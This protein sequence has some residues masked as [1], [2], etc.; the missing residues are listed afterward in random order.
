MNNMRKIM[1]ILNEDIQMQTTMNEGIGGAVNYRTSKSSPDKDYV[2]QITRNGEKLEDDKYQSLEDAKRVITNMKKGA[3]PSSKE[4]YK[5][6]KMKRPKLAGP[7]GKLPEAAPGD[8][9]EAGGKRVSIKTPW[10]FSGERNEEGEF[11]ENLEAQY[12]V[13]I[14]ISWLRGSA[15][16][17]GVPNDLVKYLKAMH[18][19]MS[20]SDMVD[21]YPE[22][23]FE[24]VSEDGILDEGAYEK[25]D[26]KHPKFK[27]NH[28]KWKEKNPS[29]TLAQFIAHMN[30][31]S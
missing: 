13:N 10:L 21:K 12:N 5:I 26:P 20:F 6:L 3:N 4:T 31:A 15:H 30:N 17:S 28:D 18:D 24:G 14:K 1:N 16:V 23:W 29:G 2:Y 19:N 22:M 25:S 8:V 11:I 27:E 7:T 9:K